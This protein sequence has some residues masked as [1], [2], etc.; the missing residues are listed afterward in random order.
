[1]DWLRLPH[2][3]GLGWRMIFLINVPIGIFAIM[4]A[5]FIPESHAPERKLLDWPGVVIVSLGFI[6]YS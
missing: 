4:M 5:R 1:M 2:F 6:L 3:G